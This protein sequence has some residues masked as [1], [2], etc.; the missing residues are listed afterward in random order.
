[1]RPRRR[2]AAH[3]RAAILVAAAA[4]LNRDAGATLETIASEAGLSRRALYGHFATRDEL[5][6][7]LLH[8][9]ATQLTRAVS[10]VDSGSSRIAIARIG[11]RL[12]AEVADVRVMAQFAVRGEFMDIVGQALG[13]VRRQ[14][15]TVVERGVRSG[16]LRQDLDPALLSRL[17]EGAAIAVLDEANRTPL[18]TEEGARLVMH[19][20]LA[21]AGLSWTESQETINE[22]EHSA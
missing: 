7:E 18:S 9:G 1:M 16:E 14:L 2:D 5:I 8:R 4:A 21:M 11:A 19:A 6:I 20:G 22:M 12:W 3:N 10:E 13:P 15:L 17:I